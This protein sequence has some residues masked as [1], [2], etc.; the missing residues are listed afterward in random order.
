VLIEYRDETG[1]ASVFRSMFKTYPKRTVLGLTLLASQAFL[2]NAIFFTYGLI[3]GEFYGIDASSVGYYIFPFALGNL[4]GPLL[5]GRLFDTLGRVP[6]I[7][8]CYFISGGLLAFTGYL[9]LQDVLTA[10]TQTVMWCIIFFFASAAASAAYLTVSEV[11][12]M[13]IRAL[14]IAIFYAIRTGVGD[15]RG[16]D[17]DGR[18]RESV[19]RAPHRRGFHDLRGHSRAVPRREGRGQVLGERRQA[20]DGCRG[21]A[22]G[23]RE[24]RHLI[25]VRDITASRKG[26]AGRG[27]GASPEKEFWR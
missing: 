21:T 27:R 4:L 6:M 24:G 26:S 16:P 10:T 17:R 1:F 3:L 13:E 25:V 14:A 19:H 18:P 11:F 5:L 22:G 9:F 8:G 12:P 7:S 20:A 23:R 15:L 2:Y